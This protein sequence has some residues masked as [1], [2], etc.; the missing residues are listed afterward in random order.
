MSTKQLRGRVEDITYHKQ[1]CAYVGRQKVLTRQHHLHV[2][3]VDECE[4]CRNRCGYSYGKDA[5]PHV[6]LVV[7]SYR[8]DLEIRCGVT[9]YWDAK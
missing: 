8:T 7:S 1:R 3:N 6:A 9:A 2:D 4:R 5:D